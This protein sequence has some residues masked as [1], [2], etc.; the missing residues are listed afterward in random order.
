MPGKKVYI[1]FFLQKNYFR[2]LKQ[3]QTNY[4]TE[5]QKVIND[6]MKI[7][8]SYIQIFLRLSKLKIFIGKI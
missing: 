8:Q 2:W 3:C 5:T 6:I 1:Y 7:C 4:A